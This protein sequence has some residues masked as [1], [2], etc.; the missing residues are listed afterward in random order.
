[1]RA[2]IM[3][4]GIMLITCPLKSSYMAGRGEAEKVD[5]RSITAYWHSEKAM[6][7]RT[8]RKILNQGLLIM[9]IYLN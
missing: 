2:N 6:C 5:A 4:R 8:R 3:T 1:M 9:E 7:S